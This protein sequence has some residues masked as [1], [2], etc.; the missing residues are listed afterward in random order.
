M[1]GKV[2]YEV[3]AYGHDGEELETRKFDIPNV[4][5]FRAECVDRISA[6]AMAGE[7][8]KEEKEHVSTER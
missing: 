7:F 3:I 6:D 2:E 4:A 5:S 8:Y 1:N